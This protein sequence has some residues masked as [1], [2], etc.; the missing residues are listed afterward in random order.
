MLEESGFRLTAV[1]RRVL[2]ALLAAGSSLSH[3]ELVD[4]LVDLDRVTVFR[5]LKFLKQAG[6]IHSVQ[7]IDGTLRYLIN[8][9]NRQ[10]C[11]GG[12]PHF[13]CME[14]GAMIC[15][16]DEAMPFVTVPEGTEVH[17]KQFLIYGVCPSCAS[18]KHDRSGRISLEGE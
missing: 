18:S 1:R 11:P 15:L 2:S 10:G 14:C 13:L 17:G 9:K 6:L 4:S 12:H 7:G 16:A 5:S 8:P 3:R